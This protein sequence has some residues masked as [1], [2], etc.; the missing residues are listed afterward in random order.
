MNSNKGGYQSQSWDLKTGYKPM[1]WR[2]TVS[3]PLCALCNKTVYPAEEVNGA[4]QKYHKLCLKCTSCN[5]LLNSG[6]LNEHETKI[7]C[8]P[9]YRRQFGP[10]GLA[11]G[12]ETTSSINTDISPTSPSSYRKETHIDNHYYERKTSTGSSP[13]RTS[14]DDDSRH[15]IS[16]PFTAQVT[17]REKPA[18]INRPSSTI[19]NGSAFKMMNISQNICPRCSKTVYSAEEV[20]AAGKSFHKRCYSCAHCKGSISGARY[21][22]H[23]GELYDNNCYQR[24]FGPKGILSTGN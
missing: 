7:Y 14:S 4:G 10:R 22:E 18:T 20:K 15:T 24:L 9:C 8:V 12:F 13:S 6:N 5:T 16:L 11:H 23:D 21:C 3:T 19:A 17:T 1:Q 2:P